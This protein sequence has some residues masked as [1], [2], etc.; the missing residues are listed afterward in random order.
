MTRSILTG[1]FFIAVS[2]LAS[3]SGAEPAELSRSIDA[4]LS[5]AHLAAGITPAPLVNDASYLR[6]VTLDL[7]GRIPTLRELRSFLDDPT[8]DKRVHLVDRLISSPDYA[9]HTR[10]EIDIQLLNRLQWNDEWRTY[11]LGATREF[12]P[13]DQ[14][15][16]EILLPE[17]AC[18]NEKGV[19]AFL[20]QR[21]KDLDAMTNDTSTLFFGVNIACAK[22]HDHPLVP[23]WQQDHYFGL[24]RFFQRTFVTRGGL[25][26]ERFDGE[27][28]FATTK[29][30]ERRAKFMFLNGKSIDEPTA[31]LSEAE[32]KDIREKLKES[33]KSNESVQPPSPPFSPRQALVDLAL[34]G[35]QS[36]LLA[37]NLAN[38]LWAQF[39]GRGLVYPVDQVHSEN[40]PSHPELL[41][42]LANALVANDY[43]SRP[44]VRG[45]LLSDAYARASAP[46]DLNQRIE[47]HFFAAQVPRP[48]TPFQYSLS[49]SVA[50]RNPELLPGPEKPA[51]WPQ[52]R[53]RWEKDSERLARRFEIPDELFQV[54][55]EEALFLSNNPQVESDFLQNRPDYLVGYLLRLPSDAQA[56]EEAFSSILSRSPTA[57]ELINLQ[58]FLDRKDQP[59]DKVLPQLVWAMLTSAEFRFNH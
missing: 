6:R 42:L 35:R 7:A 53:E 12:R 3:L 39:M 49:L 44:I 29:G 56:I 32:W 28:K 2:M 54:S 25:I 52:T 26:A 41:E 36:S 8:E 5:K 37:K 34:E 22:C 9:F 47:P 21:A 27:L 10:N 20:K 51:D 45:I 58:A 17:K 38:R 40:P 43:D 48:L 1:I 18:E 15:V 16:R 14:L 31:T 55:V 59:R 13:W 57:D 30:E 19:A 46:A 11:L 4:I 24:A 50:S 33:E 23:D